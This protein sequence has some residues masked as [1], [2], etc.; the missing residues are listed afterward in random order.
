MEIQGE[1]IP[2]IQGLA[3]NRHKALTTWAMYGLV[4]TIPYIK[5]PSTVA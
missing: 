3:M 4:Q 1:K 5:L 2:R